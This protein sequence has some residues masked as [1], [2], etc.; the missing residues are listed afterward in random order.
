MPMVD[1]ML[2]VVARSTMLLLQVAMR[3]NFRYHG[4]LLAT[5]HGKSTHRSLWAVDA[6]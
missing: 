3:M 4:A 6:T 1:M 5:L 2:I